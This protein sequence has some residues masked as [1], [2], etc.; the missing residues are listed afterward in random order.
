MSEDLRNSCA[1]H[2]PTPAFSLARCAKRHAE[3]ASE[4]YYLTDGKLGTS[5]RHRE[6]ASFDRLAGL[7]CVRQAQLNW[8][9]KTDWP[10]IG[11]FK[12]TFISDYSGLQ[13]IAKPQV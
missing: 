4:H 12:G 8:R 13:I 9:D 10:I 11:I 2:R 3:C 7:H 6:T 5:A 1:R